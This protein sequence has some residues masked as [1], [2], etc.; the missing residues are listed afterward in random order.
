MGV[1]SVLDDNMINTIAAG[2]VIERPASVVKEL[3]ENR[4]QI[5]PNEYGNP[6]KEL[7][8]FTLKHFEKHITENPNEGHRI[9]KNEFPIMHPYIYRQISNTQNEIDGS[10]RD[11]GDQYAC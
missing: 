4:Y 10:E 1:I 3:V 5:L 2:E 7:I 6:F 9:L 8:N 11:R